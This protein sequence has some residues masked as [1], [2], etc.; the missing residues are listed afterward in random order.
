MFKSWLAEH[1]HEHDIT[2][3]KFAQIVGQAF[4]KHTNADHGAILYTAID[5]M[6]DALRSEEVESLMV[7]FDQAHSDNPNLILWSDY[8]SIVEILLDFTRSE[9][10]SNWIPHLKA[11]TAMLPWLTIY[12][13][14]KYAR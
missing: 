8:M 5:N 14:T 4:K 2:V 7:E 10:D 3:E 11:F 13:R 1:G 9:R 12:D 6:S